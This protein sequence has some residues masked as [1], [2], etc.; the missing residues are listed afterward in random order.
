MLLFAG[1]A[2]VAAYAA[3]GAGL[4]PAL[5]ALALLNS[6]YLVLSAS[7]ASHVADFPLRRR[8]VVGYLLTTEAYAAT[9]T[10]LTRLRH[11]PPPLRWAYLLGAALPVW[12]VFQLAT[13]GGALAGATVPG[14]D[15][16][17]VA[18]PLA[19]LALLVPAL[20]HRPAVV[21]AL[22]SVAVAVVLARVSPPL[23]LPLASVAGVLAG[24][25]VRRRD[26]T[27]APA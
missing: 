20:T 5:G 26:S 13:L 12:V 14:A 25:A 7:M 21:T 17:R 9:A 8:A 6:C 16:L 15:V 10:E 18:V 4:L 2:Q 22:V 3:L 27:E 23:S 11:E 19:F 1:T 24:A